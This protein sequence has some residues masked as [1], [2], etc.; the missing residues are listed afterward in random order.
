MA[1]LLVVLDPLSSSGSACLN[2]LSAASI[3]SSRHNVY[4][5]A[6]CLCDNALDNAF[7]RRSAQPRL[8]VLDLCN[9]PDVLQA[10]LAN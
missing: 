6:A 10:D 4:S 5:Q 9:L 1:L 2:F 8:R 3:P 7:K